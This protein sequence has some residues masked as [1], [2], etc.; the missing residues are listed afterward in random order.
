MLYNKAPFLFCVEIVFVA[1]QTEVE[2]SH[3]NKQLSSS[4]C[5]AHWCS[6]HPLLRG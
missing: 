4:F 1:K 2:S 6:S 5:I 3:S